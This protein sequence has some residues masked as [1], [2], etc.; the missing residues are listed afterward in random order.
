[1]TT[2]R[3]PT[4]ITAPPNTAFLE[5]T[6][7][8]DAP[9][10]AVFRAHVEPELLARWLG[11]RDLEMH[12]EYWDARSGGSYRYVHSRPAQNF[13]VG[14]R[15]T[16]HAVRPSELIIQTFEFDGAPDQ[17]TLDTFRLADL[18]GRTRLVTR[19]VFPSVE[20]REAALASGMT[21]GIEESYERLS[22]LLGT[23]S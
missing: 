9:R 23:A 18:G 20:A 1:M 8:F 12:V 10:E 7:E 15:G 4:V 6:R 2:S 21:R 16:F 11:P 5:I 22:E 13:A 3:H 14:F 17:V 19:S